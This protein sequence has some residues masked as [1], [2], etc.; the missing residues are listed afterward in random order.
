M[1]S[2]L[3]NTKLSLIPKAILELNEI[4]SDV[5]VNTQ[6]VLF[7]R[8]TEGFNI[9][10]EV[11]DLY[12]RM[13]EH[14]YSTS[15]PNQR[16]LVDN[17]HS[18]INAYSKTTVGYAPVFTDNRKFFANMINTADFKRTLQKDVAVLQSNIVEKMKFCDDSIMTESALKSLYDREVDQ[19]KQ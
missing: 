8:T 16:F 3:L 14:C 6:I 13:F 19:T 15:M 10:Y 9:A 4:T 17:L 7:C 12:L 1:F 11:F 5:E 18:Y 2:C